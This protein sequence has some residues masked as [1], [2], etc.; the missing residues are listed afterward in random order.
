V[1]YLFASE[2]LELQSG[3]LRE[4][5]EAIGGDDRIVMFRSVESLSARLHRHNQPGIM[6]FLI[7][8]RKDLM[9]VSSNR[10]AILDAD[11][12]LLVADEEAE[13]Y[14]LAHGL[15][16]SY[17]GLVDSDLDRVV[18]VLRRLLKKRGRQSG[19]ENGS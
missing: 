19:T 17:L 13:T 4:I 1:D 7:G 9:G 10:D 12:I 8:S 11:T 2:S 14:A 18:P 15:R 6:I 16:P 3:M 5:V